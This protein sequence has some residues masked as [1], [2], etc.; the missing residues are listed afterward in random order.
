MEKRP[1]G[2]AVSS[3]WDERHSPSEENTPVYTFQQQ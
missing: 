1:Q 2:S 3:G